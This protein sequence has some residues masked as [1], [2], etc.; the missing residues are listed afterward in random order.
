MRHPRASCAPDPR[1]GRP[2]ALLRGRRQHAHREH[3]S[4]VRRVLSWLC[5]QGEAARRVGLGGGSGGSAAFRLPL[6]RARAHAA[7]IGVARRPR[8]V[9]RPAAARARRAA[10]VAG[11][12]R[13]GDRASRDV[14][15]G[16]GG[17]RADA[18][19]RLHRAAGL[20]S[21]DP[22]D[23]HREPRRRGARH[24]RVPPPA[25]VAPALLRAPAYRRAHGPA[26][27]HRGHPGVRVRRGDHPRARR[28][29]PARVRGRDALL[30]RPRSRCSPWPPSRC[31]R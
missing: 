30:Q 15:A 6:V 31:W 10:A 2:R 27:G 18:D 14:D 4:G 28:A 20:D 9:A 25:R 5:P 12:H 3:P 1:G 8:G 29:V 7:Q 21:P 16:R 26:R 22:G 19:R 11:R 24:H 13:Q 23:P 17:G